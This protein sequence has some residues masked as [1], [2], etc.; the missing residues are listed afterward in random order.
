M[1]GPILEEAFNKSGRIILIFSVNM[2]GFFQG[3]AQMMSSVGWRWDN[4]WSQ[5]SGGNNPWGCCFKVKWLQL[6]NLP[7]YKNE[8]KP[9]KISRDCQELSPEIGEA[10]CELIDKETEEDEKPACSLRDK[11]NNGHSIYMNWARSSMLYPSLFYQHR[12][13]ANRLYIAQEQSVGAFPRKGTKVKNPQHMGNSAGVQVDPETSLFNSGGLSSES[14][15]LCNVIPDDKFLEM[16]YEEYL[17]AHSR[18]SRHLHQSAAVP[19]L[20]KQ[21]TLTKERG[22]DS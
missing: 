14:S 7:F 17:E 15:S 1:N 4:V 13:E 9:V 11:G 3:Y 22:E 16:S 6:N 8:Y 5:G 10:L 20:R 21:D 2:S 18:N 12:A 19:S